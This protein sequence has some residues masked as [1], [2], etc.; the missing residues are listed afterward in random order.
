MQYITISYHIIS[1]G[2]SAKYGTAR[3]PWHPSA[4]SSARSPRHFHSRW[5]PGQLRESGRCPKR[6]HLET[7][8]S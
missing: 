8:D 2:L 6:E 5:P 4:A 7:R 1:V 3:L